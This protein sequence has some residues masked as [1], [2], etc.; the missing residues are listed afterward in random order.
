ML[1]YVYEQYYKILS[2]FFRRLKI[3]MLDCT[4]IRDHIGKVAIRYR[5]DNWLIWIA[6]LIII[7]LKIIIERKLIVFSWFSRKLLDRK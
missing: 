7:V 3:I 4:N 6:E 1:I 2:S 5:L